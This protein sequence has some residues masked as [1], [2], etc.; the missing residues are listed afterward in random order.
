MIARTHLPAPFTVQGGGSDLRFPHHEFS[1]AHATASDGVA[2]A[3]HYAHTGMVGLEGEKMSKS[4]G[5]L[6]LV[7]VLRERG[8][9]P[10]AI[11]TLLLGHHWQSEWSYTDEGLEA[12]SQRLQA[13][14]NRLA[15]LPEHGAERP[16][17]PEE[18]QYALV[19]ALSLNLNAPA[20]LD[21]LDRWA[22]GE[23]AAGTGATR[24]REVVLALLG[25]DLAA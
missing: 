7:S 4:Q 8:E 16:E 10:Q 22:A 25:L 13:W 15:Q 2:L 23:L 24:V 14:N 6:V 11:R 21:Q 5:N 12:A 9:A 3:H 20:A 1:A 19:S 18:L 17:E